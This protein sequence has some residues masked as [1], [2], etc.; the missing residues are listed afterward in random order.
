MTRTRYHFPAT[1]TAVAKQTRVL[2]TAK[3]GTQ[4][5]EDLGWGLRLTLDR[6]TEFTF[7]LHEE[8]RAKRGDTLTLIL[9][10]PT[11]SPK[12]GATQ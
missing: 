2:R 9:E 7:T 5:L 12:P 8:P 10:I 3:D 11:E 1:V 4:D 6:T